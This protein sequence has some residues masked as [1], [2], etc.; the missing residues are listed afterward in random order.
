MPMRFHS[1]RKSVNTQ[2]SKSRDQ[3][4]TGFTPNLLTRYKKILMP[5]PNPSNA[6]RVLSPFHLL[7]HATL[8]SLFYLNG[9]QLKPLLHPLIAFISSHRKSNSSYQFQPKSCVN[10]SNPTQSRVKSLNDAHLVRHQL[11]FP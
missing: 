6:S 9:T 1:E 3:A 4:Y 10:P 7:T 2:S 5:T 8:F 11:V